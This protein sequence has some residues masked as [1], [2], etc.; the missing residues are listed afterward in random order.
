MFAG[1][2]FARRTKRSGACGTHGSDIQRPPPPSILSLLEAYHEWGLFSRNGPGCPDGLPLVVAA[3]SLEYDGLNMPKLQENQQMARCPADRP[4]LLAPAGDWGC[5]RA[6]LANGADAVY[7]GLDDFNARRRAA[8]FTLAELPEVL[9]YVHHRNARAYV[10][11]N[12]LVF[13]NELPTVT[14]YVRA[15]AAAGADA[16]I[17]Q[18]LGLACLIRRLAPTLEIHASTQTTQTEETGIA[19]LR[20]LGFGRV[21]L[22]RELALPEIEQV[23]RGTAMPLEVFVHGAI[24]ISYSGQCLASE[25]LWGRSANRGLCAQAC[26]LPYQLIVDGQ[27]HDLK[28]RRYLLSAQDLSAWDRIHALV[29]SGIAG[30]KIE[31]RLKSADYV[32]AAVKLY[33]AAVDAALQ[34]QPFAPSPRQQQELATIF[35]R[36]LCHGF[37]D[38]VDHQLLV[39]GRYPK[40]RG[41]FIGEVI[42]KTRQGIVVSLAT[43]NPI[44][45]GDGVVFDEGRPDQDEQGG[46]IYTLK[47]ASHR[48]PTG[49]RA[50]QEALE[51][52]FGRDDV[53]LAAVA[54]GAKVWKTDDPAVRRSLDRSRRHHRPARLAPLTVRV[55]ARVGQALT[56]RMSDTAGHEATVSWEGPL[57]PADK[58]PLTTELLREQFSRLG[59]TPFGLAELEL[60]GEAG[61]VDS[62]PVMAPKSVLND[63]RRRGVE[64]LLKQRE[65]SHRHAV[66]DAGVLDELRE[67]AK[68]FLAAAPSDKTM[69]PSLSVLV[70]SLEQLQAVL[71]WAS[72]DRRRRE[73]LLYCDLGDANQTALA[74]RLCRAAGCRVGI[75]TPRILMPGEIGSLDRIASLTPDAVLVRNL[76]TL[77]HFR[78]EHPDLASIGDHSFN[79]ANEITAGLLWRQGLRRLTP[80]HDLNWAQLR[81]MLGHVPPS[82]L[83]VV[84]HQHVPMLHMRHCLYGANL[85]KAASC[86]EC[87]RPCMKHEIK[88]RDRDGRDH[89]VLVDQFG[90]NTVFNATAQTAVE[91]IPMMIDAGLR[92]FRLELLREQA[93]EVAPLV[94]IYAAMLKGEMTAAV[95]LQTIRTCSSAPVGRGALAFE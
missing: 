91:F 57:R 71:D 10:T 44:K 33:R 7:F 6:A 41:L 49:R 34:Q 52:G 83:E 90:R 42:G 43:T 89:L 20:S 37:L 22:A 77:V 12:T 1:P 84:I 86:A 85:S 15:I 62:A 31:G 14:Q 21:I 93:N 88:L 25:S 46:R 47:P 40:N 29:S 74:A 73:T 51:L 79:V 94:N 65:A 18:D 54:V 58:H 28:D 69:L 76:G 5:L 67:E 95:G 50:E 61:V 4:E 35:S 80:S 2:H 70:R 81:A 3:V 56:I 72:P 68:S 13:A 17:V 82:L 9:A 32:A 66:A 78:K 64:S 48:S 39:H 26:R 59:G 63:L 38:G 75:A 19:F 87:D 92:H 53:D 23:R 45:P 55:D 8:N 27:V 30:F 36:G 60:R 11:L 24:C 16:V